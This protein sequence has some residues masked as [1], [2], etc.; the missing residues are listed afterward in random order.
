MNHNVFY[1]LLKMIRNENMRE[2]H[3]E[4]SLLTTESNNFVIS[5]ANNDHQPEQI[6]SH[7]IATRDQQDIVKL[8]CSM[9]NSIQAVTPSGVVDTCK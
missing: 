5:L 4:G 2:N 7:Y 3:S 6:L 9:P 8:E 1:C